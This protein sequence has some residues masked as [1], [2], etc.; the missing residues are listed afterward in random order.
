MNRMLPL[1]VAFVSLGLMVGASSARQAVAS[2]LT[3]RDL[4]S[5]YPFN[6][7]VGHRTSPQNAAMK[8]VRYVTFHATATGSG[9]GS[10]AS[11]VAL[12]KSL[13]AEKHGG[14]PYHFIVGNSGTV[15]HTRPLDRVA[16][17]NTYYFPMEGEDAPK[18]Y[19]PKTG[20]ADSAELWTHYTKTLDEEFEHWWEKH[21]QQQQSW[22]REAN[23]R[24]AKDPNKETNKELSIPKLKRE[25]ALQRLVPG[26]SNGHVTISFL[27]AVGA[28]P[29]AEALDS[30]AR[31]AAEILHRERLGLEAI[32]VHFE[33]AYTECPGSAIYE[34][35]RME[36]RNGR[37]NTVRS[38][39]SHGDGALK[40]GDYL[41]DLQKLARE[42]RQ[43]RRE[44]FF[45]R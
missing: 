18:K 2:F 22:L 16:A 43:P 25:S 23:E 12:I 40:I 37:V 5:E 9:N 38:P 10:S 26:H 35:L 1:F 4:L 31:L 24:I 11:E 32:R 17:S 27:G 3:K 20:E 41:L 8:K 44:F 39:S 36:K 15:Y 19:D 13:I 21:P 33:A 6:K 14:V 45:R 42:T 30:A 34:W 28:R 7:P 29:T